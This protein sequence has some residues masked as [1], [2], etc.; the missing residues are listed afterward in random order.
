M[1]LLALVFSWNVLVGLLTLA[2]VFVLVAAGGSGES[3]Q[4]AYVLFALAGVAALFAII[5][6]IQLYRA[7]RRWRANDGRSSAA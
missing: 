7:I 2:A 1:A 6:Y 3:A 4:I 5:R